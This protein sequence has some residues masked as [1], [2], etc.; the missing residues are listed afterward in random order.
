M[1]SR[2]MS[3]VEASQYLLEKHGIRRS[4]GY[5]A[6]IAVQGDGP[7]YRLAGLRQAIYS[8]QDLDAY[9]KKILSKPAAS[10]AAHA[11]GAR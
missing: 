8:P 9:A 7:K 5:L 4:P 11:A 10:S 3:R 2:P 6:K 1:F